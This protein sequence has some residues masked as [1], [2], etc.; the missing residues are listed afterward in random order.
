MTSNKNDRETESKSE[1]Q[2]NPAGN[3]SDQS[4]QKNLTLEE[5]MKIK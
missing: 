3:M 1:T 5:K 2:D 4:G